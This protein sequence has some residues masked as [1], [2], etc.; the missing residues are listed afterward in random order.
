MTSDPLQL[1]TGNDIK[2]LKNYFFSEN[3]EL[4]YL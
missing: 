4:K 2:G 3:Y 1:E